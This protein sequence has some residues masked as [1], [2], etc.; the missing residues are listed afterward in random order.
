MLPCL[1]PVLF[2]FNLQGVLKFKCKIPAAK[3]YAE[4]KVQWALNLLDIIAKKSNLKTYTI[5]TE[6]MKFK[7]NKLIRGK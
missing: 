2:A 3:G 5:R 6:L 4:G 1:I 7:G